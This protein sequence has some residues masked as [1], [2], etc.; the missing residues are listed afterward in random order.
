M[1]KLPKKCSYVFKSFIATLGPNGPTQL[2]P[3]Q[4]QLRSW[5]HKW[6]YFH[7]PVQPSVHRETLDLSSEPLYDL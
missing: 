2:S 7:V 6:H 3:S 1:K 4:P 5:G